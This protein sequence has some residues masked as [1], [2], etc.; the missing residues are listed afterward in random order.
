MSSF[1]DRSYYGNS[2][3]V[4]DVFKLHPVK[5][6]EI[7]F[8]KRLISPQKGEKLLDIGCGTGAYLMGLEGNGIDL[9][10]I[11]LSE[12]ATEIARK[13]VSNP[14]QI[15]CA[16]ADPL[17]FG[18]NIFDYVTALGI[19]EHFPS[20]P[21]IL[22]EMCRV[23]KPQGQAVIMV[24]NIYYYKFIWDTLRKGA[25]PVRHQEIEALYSF[26]RWKQFIEE[27]GLT[28]LRVSH[29]NKFNKPLLTWLRNLFIPYYFSN[30]FIFICT[31]K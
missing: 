18:D 5:S 2:E 9:W 16:N 3:S 14:Q 30:H 25:G 31:K 27:A 6:R 29:H 22:S 21:S 11:D 24:P 19:V 20:I 17:P 7:E 23:I 4:A 13:R 10:G 15:L 8:F 26:A 1:Y 12:N 28:V